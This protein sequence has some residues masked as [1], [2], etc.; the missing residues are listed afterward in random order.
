MHL[1]TRRWGRAVEAGRKTVP[2][3]LFA[4]VVASLLWLC[5]VLLHSLLVLGASATLAWVAATG[6]VRALVAAGPGDSVHTLLAL[7]M[8]AEVGPGGLAL[9]P[10]AEGLHSTDLLGAPLRPLLGVVFPAGSSLVGTHLA[11]LFVNVVIVAAGAALL[12]GGRHRIALCFR[13]GLLAIALGGGRQ[14]IVSWAPGS[15]GEMV[16]SM[17]ATK[18]FDVAGPAY[19]DFIHASGLPVSLVLNLLAVTVAGAAGGMVGVGARQLG[20]TRPGPARLP[21]VATGWKPPQPSFIPDRWPA[22]VQRASVLGSG[23]LFP[24]FGAVAAVALL[25]VTP[26]AVERAA[27]LPVSAPVLAPADAP[28]PD[29]HGPSHVAVRKGPG[30]YEYVVNG[31]PRR[32]RCIGYNAMTDDLSATARSARYDADFAALRA[33]R[34]NTVLGWNQSMFDDETLLAAAHRHGL[35]VILHYNLSA[36][37][38]YTDAQFTDSLLNG[39]R[40]WVLRHRDN[41]AV[42]MWGVGNEVLH[43]YDNP[44]DPRAGAFAR[45]L[46]RAADTVHGE[47]LNH[48]VIYRDAEDV[49]LS[50]IDQALRADGVARPW[51]VYGMNFF[52]Y[53]LDAAL[54]EGPALALGQPLLVSEFAPLGIAPSD[55]PVGYLRFWGIVRSHRQ[56]VLGGCAYVWT[57]AGPEPVDQTLGLTDR[58]GAPVDGSLQVLAAV[59]TGDEAAQDPARTSSPR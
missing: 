47:D 16:L 38:D 15:G 54:K 35:G 57:R 58:D 5:L 55:R 14:L 13:L 49:F 32:I 8:V 40:S 52:T 11:L 22:L 41:P 29:F 2:R 51:F 25:L 3:L 36:A 45:F 21:D 6:P 28:P 24:S 7:N 53:R 31:R 1:P 12:A 46:V 10:R 27:G 37:W 30:G 44:G 9:L 43:K 20:R 42:R 50:P 59:F 19:Q 18:V 34:V 33:A 26:I 4:F 56:R 17:V 48:P 39:I 23:R